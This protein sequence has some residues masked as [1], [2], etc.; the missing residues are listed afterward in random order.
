[1]DGVVIGTVNVA[2]DDV[3]FRPNSSASAGLV[4]LKVTKDETSLVAFQSQEQERGRL[5]VQGSGP[6]LE[7]LRGYARAERADLLAGDRWTSTCKGIEKL[8]LPINAP[9]SGSGTRR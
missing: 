4:K 2:G 7:V 1:M 8:T 3:V 5:T 9:S 6:L